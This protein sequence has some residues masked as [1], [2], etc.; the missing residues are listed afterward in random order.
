MPNHEEIYIHQAEMYESLISKQPNL[1]EIMNEIRPYH[2]LDVVDLGAGSGRLSKCI[3][4]MANTLMSTDASSAMLDLLEKGMQN[5]NLNNWSTLVADHRNL[6]I[7]TSSVDLVVSGWSICYLASSNHPDWK[8]NLR[9][10]LS[11]INRILRND[12]TKD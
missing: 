4:P 7:E 12:G 5:Q 6:P 10:I 3:A 8:A 9:T 1:S 11:E 2:N